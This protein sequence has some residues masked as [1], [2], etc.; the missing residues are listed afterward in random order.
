M[1]IPLEFTLNDVLMNHQALQGAS[2]RAVMN[3]L[4]PISLTLIQRTFK[5]SLNA[6]LSQAKSR[7]SLQRLGQLVSASSKGH[8]PLSSPAKQPLSYILVCNITGYRHELI[9][10]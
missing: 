4:T 2:G 10:C 5:L 3:L 1:I 6:A 8:G 9:V 7:S